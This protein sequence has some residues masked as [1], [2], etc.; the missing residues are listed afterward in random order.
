MP[1]VMMD[2]AGPHEF[3]FNEAFSFQVFCRDQT[4]IDAYW[5]KLSASGGFEMDCG[6]LKNKFGISWQIVPEEMIKWMKDQKRARKTSN[7]ILKMK[8]LN[9]TVLGGSGEC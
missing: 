5:T 4:E 1:I 7:A 2:G 8:K 9:L 3:A 6:W